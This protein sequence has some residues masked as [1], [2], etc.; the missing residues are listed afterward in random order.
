MKKIRLNLDLL[1]VESFPTARAAAGARGTVRANA[2]DPQ[3]YRQ[4]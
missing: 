1:H 3:T 4:E 2:N